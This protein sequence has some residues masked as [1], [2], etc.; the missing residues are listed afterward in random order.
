MDLAK[1]IKN[2]ENE[3]ATKTAEKALAE[4][5]IK[6]IKKTLEEKGIDP[7]DLSKAIEDKKK[8]IEKVEEELEKLLKE[9]EE[10]LENN[11]T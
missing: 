8:E 3:V 9:A 11:R 2:I 7:K 10:S 4:K 5:K 1:R 6:E